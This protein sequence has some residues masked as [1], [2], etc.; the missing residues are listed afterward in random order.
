MLE[1]D[2]NIRNYAYY[3]RAFMKTSII[4]L[5]IND[6]KVYNLQ[7]VYLMPE[8]RTLEELEKHEH[9]VKGLCGLYRFHYSPR[10]HV[11]QLGG[12]RGV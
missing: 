11:T 4:P 6:N 10:L 7:E 5:V 2:A 9:L 8:G 12:V 1:P 3:R